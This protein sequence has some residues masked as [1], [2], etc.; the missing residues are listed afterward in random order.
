MTPRLRGTAAAAAV[1]LA[2]VLGACSSPGDDAAAPAGGDVAGVASTT[3]G[4]D[5]DGAPVTDGVGPAA[6]PSADGTTEAPAPAPSA[7]PVAT[8]TAEPVA[9][10][11][12]A[13]FEGGLVAL[14]TAVEAVDVEAR[15]PGGVS[16]PGRLVR[17]EL[18]NGSDVAV[19]LDGV[20]VTATVDDGS[21]A[22]AVSGSPTEPVGGE[23][24]P[25]ASASGTYAF[26]APE[27]ASLRVE[28]VQNEQPD[29]V[30]VQQ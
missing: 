25:G 24:A 20:A 16:G 21:P 26:T 3:A 1:G 7:P 6:T 29:V 14:V 9:V 11:E 23:L 18:E 2:L 8:R 10:G 15:G 17:L 27:G 30:V 13:P 28:V 19:D 5:A 22:P 4:G 12:D